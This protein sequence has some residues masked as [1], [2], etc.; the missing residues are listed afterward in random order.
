LRLPLRSKRPAN[1]HHITPLAPF[2]RGIFRV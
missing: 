1:P 2:S